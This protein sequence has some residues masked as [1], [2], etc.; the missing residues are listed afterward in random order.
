MVGAGSVSKFEVYKRRFEVESELRSAR[1]GMTYM[2]LHVEKTISLNYAFPVEHRE[3]FCQ[4][5]YPAKQK[6]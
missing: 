3:H 6:S 5:L 1:S 2:N 4:T